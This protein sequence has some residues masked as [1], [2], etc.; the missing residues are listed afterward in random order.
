VILDRLKPA[1]LSQ[2]L[3]DPVLSTELVY[4]HVGEWVCLA[5][6]KY[7]KHPLWARSAILK[8][9]VPWL[10]SSIAPPHDYLRFGQGY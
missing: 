9:P 5:L 1:I 4:N 6:P 10:R 8:V 2:F 3:E 7:G